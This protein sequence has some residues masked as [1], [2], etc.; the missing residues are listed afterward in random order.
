MGNI[1]LLGD[2]HTY[3]DG[4]D[5]VSFQDP[6]NGH[7]KKTWAYHMFPAD[8]ITNKS[9][10]GCSNDMIAL[11]LQRYFKGWHRVAKPNCAVII[12]FTYY[13]RFHITRNGCNFIIR[14]DDSMAISD[15]SDENRVAKKINEK[16]ES[17]NKRLMVDHFD[18]NMLELMFLKNILMCQYFCIANNIRYYFTMTDH[19]AK[20]KCSASLQRYRDSLYDSIDW[21][22]IFLVD[23]RLGFS[24]YAREINATKGSDN[25]HYGE[26]Y[27]K[28][29]GKLFL[30]WI[31][32]EK[33]L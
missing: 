9:Y 30:D 8:K 2:S 18:D 6:W 20:T 28:K 24:N 31:N 26:E 19:R 33:V 23:N 17:K 22:K 1:L 25:Q 13:E 7:S 4:L 3:G 15:N 14:P 21:T 10:T 11:K 16:F 5:D 27:H 12:M 32:K 29:F